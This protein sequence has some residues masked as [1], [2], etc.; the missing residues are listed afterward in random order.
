M[1]NV[2]VKEF[3]ITIN[4]IE[5]TFRL[6]FSALLKFTNRYENAMM[7]FNE[8]L[9]GKNV[10]DCIVKILSCSCAEKDF[11]ETEL[12]SY[13]SFDFKTMKLMD[14]IT[15]ALIEGLMADEKEAKGTKKAKN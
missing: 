15:F 1:V 14:E 8:F 3:K 5:Y 9:A 10:Y 6:D 4:K 2:E 12:N 11:T 13:L 7:L